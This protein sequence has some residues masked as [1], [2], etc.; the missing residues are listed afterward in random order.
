[1]KTL[2]NILLYLWQ[3]PQNL[4]GLLL[5][6]VLRPKK[7]YSLDNGSIVYFSKRMP[8]GISLGKY[9]I[10][11]SYHFRESLEATLKRDTVRHEAI[12]HAMQSRYL[13]WLYL[14]VIGLPSIVWTALYGSVI[15]TSRNGYYRFYTERWADKLAGVNR[16]D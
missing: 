1:M 10:V 5:V 13:G 3:L 9:S 12:G 7:S 16:N 4:L 15:K 2:K 6:A 14:I 8:G 11:A